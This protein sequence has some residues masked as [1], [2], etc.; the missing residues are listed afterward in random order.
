MPAAVA[1]VKTPE[2]PRLHHCPHR[3]T[4]ASE[5]RSALPV[6]QQGVFAPGVDAPKLHFHRLLHAKYL[7]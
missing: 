7:W 4:A 6:N 2:A 5:S 3:T 1:G